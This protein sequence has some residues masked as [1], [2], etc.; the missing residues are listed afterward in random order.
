MQENL[1]LLEKFWNQEKSLTFIT[2][3]SNGKFLITHET[4][5]STASKSAGDS[6]V[7]ECLSL[8]FFEKVKTTYKSRADVFSIKLTADKEILINRFNEHLKEAENLGAKISNKSLSVFLELYEKYNS[9][10]ELGIM[11]NTSNISIFEAVEQVEDF[12]I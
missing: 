10:P 8:E 11:I 7:I 3:F 6:L 4:I 2:I 9:E 1:P 12:F 5:K